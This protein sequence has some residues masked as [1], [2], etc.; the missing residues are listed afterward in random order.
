MNKRGELLEEFILESGLLVENIGTTPT[1]ATWRGNT[2]Y[3]SAIDVT[4]TKGEV[5]SLIHI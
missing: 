4:L 3:E 1:F 2:F 5:L